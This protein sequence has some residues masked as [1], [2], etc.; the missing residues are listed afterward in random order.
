MK[1]VM[2]YVKKTDDIIICDN[3]YFSFNM[4]QRIGE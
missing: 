2:M 4:H 3:M 1:L